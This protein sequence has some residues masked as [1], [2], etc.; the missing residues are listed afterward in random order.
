MSETLNN[1]HILKAAYELLIEKGFK[2]TTMDSL[3]KKLQMSK[4]TLY[5]IYESKTDLI[6]KAL[7][8]N[9]LLH[10]KE[11]DEAF[12]NSSNLIEGLVKIFKLHREQ[13][14]NISI[15]FFHDLD[16]LYPYLKSDIERNRKEVIDQMQQMF[17]Q[18]ISEGVFLS[19]LNYKALTHIL[20]LQMESVKRMEKHI[21]EELSLPV[22]FDT[23]SICFLRSIVSEKGR[24]L[25]DENIPVL[26]P[27]LRIS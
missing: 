26:Y 16:R 7:E 8:R 27:E 1:D 24:K 6:L 14:K 11:C 19:Q 22:I 25:L 15:D 5:E 9:R 13:M 3:A 10:R 17:A 18:G 23:M 21:T 12:K 20:L 2:A 4:R